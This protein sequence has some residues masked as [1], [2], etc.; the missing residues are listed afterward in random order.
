MTLTRRTFLCSAT[1]APFL[2]AARAAQGRQAV[3]RSATEFIFESGKIY[4]DPY[5]EIELDVV[6]RDAS[7]KPQRVPAFWAGGQEWRVRYAADA[8]GSY[9]F[10]TICSDNSNPD[11]HGRTGVLEVAPYEGANPLLRHGAPRVSEDR[12]H[13]E[14]ADGTPFFWLGRHMVDGPVEAPA[15]A[16]G[17]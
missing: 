9:A 6:F 3:A 16:L 4:H 15:M 2:L 7:G 11:L 13:L 1:A 8:A 17:F 12:R 10:E 14:H 5:N